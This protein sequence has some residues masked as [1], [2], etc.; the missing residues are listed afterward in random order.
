MQRKVFQ[1]MIRWKDGNENKPLLLVGPKCV[2][3]TYLAN[4]FGKTYYKRI[5][6]INFE[7]QP[8][9]IELFKKDIDTTTDIN[10]ILKNISNTF[11][12]QEEE[13]SDNSPVLFIFD[14]ITFLPFYSEIIE[15]FQNSDMT[16]P[17]ILI[18]STPNDF[19]DNNID[20]N[21]K[22]MILHIFSFDFE[23]F[24]IAI[25]YTW[26][27]D[28]IREHYNTNKKLPSIVHNELLS[29][30]ELY[31]K[32]GGMPL[33]IN[34]YL[35]NKN[36]NNIREVHRIIS[37]FCI[38]TLN[39]G[40]DDSLLLKIRHV[41]SSI[42]KQ[43]EK[44][45]K[46][47]QYRLIRKGVTKK[48][49]QDAINQIINSNLAIKCSKLIQYSKD[50]IQA[51]QDAFK[52]YHMDV[53]ILNSNGNELDQS[54]RKGVF[55]NYIAQSLVS[56][57]YEPYFWESNSQAKIDFVI[58]KNQLLLPIEVKVDNNTRSK[59]L[60]IFHSFFNTKNSIKVSTRNFEFSNH[61]KYIPIYAVF[62]I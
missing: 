12:F 24:L 22:Y 3:K 43:L 11:D 1:N 39:T 31:L 38:N 55:E 50:I 32:I 60:S 52:L 41:I 53:G 59:S 28:V 40:N 37:D 58:Q 20:A 30:F 18:S 62:C 51:D 46:K 54:F 47:F 44:E 61:V 34:E 56:N 33:A 5:I 42:H 21:R 9:M 8:E 13:F 10:K 4:E 15:L 29:L 25:G 36:T 27:A 49:Y 14:E 17:V 35:I 16:L 57:G 26:Y 7:N 19:F 6:Y 23:E 45:N 2:G 48:L